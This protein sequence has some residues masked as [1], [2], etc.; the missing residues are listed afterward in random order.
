VKVIKVDNVNGALLKFVQMRKESSVWRNI[1]PR[2]GAVTMEYVEPV[3]T[4]YER[5]WRRVLFSQLRDANPF[6]H[7]FE[8]LWML[9]GKRDAEWLSQFSSG[10]AKYAEDDGLFHGAYGHRWRYRFAVDQL[11]E[12]TTL[13]SREPDTRRAVLAMWDPHD[14]LGAVKRDLPCNT[15]AYFKI[16]EGALHMTVLCRSNDIVLGCYGANAVHFSVL[17]EYVAAMSGVSMGTYTHVSDSWHYYVDNPFIKKLDDGAIMD[18]LN[19]YTAGEASNRIASISVVP[20]GAAEQ[21][22]WHTDL[23]AFMSHD[24]HDA[25]LYG[26]L[27]FRSVALPMRFAWESYKNEDLETAK[28]R[29]SK[30]AAPDWKLACAAWINRR[31]RV[32]L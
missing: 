8:S 22:T 30:I 3:T 20:S 9:S 14:D 21:A 25:V 24:W 11:T 7:L 19:Y 28:H 6:F 1:A 27:F 29:A 23:R 26:S 2:D 18:G 4:V 13:L 17:Q 15:H 12:L 10:I 5:P 16:R 31:E 32:R